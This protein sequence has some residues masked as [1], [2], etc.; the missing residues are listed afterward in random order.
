MAEFNLLSTLR[1]LNV[2]GPEKESSDALRF[3]GVKDVDTA[4]AT[5]TA[6][7]EKVLIRVKRKCRLVGAYVSPS[8]AVTGAA[9][10]FFTVLIDKRLAAAPATNV[11]LITYAADTA[12][13]DDIA[14]FGSK[15]LLA[16]ATLAT[17]L[18]APTAADLNFEEGDVATLE[19]TKAGTGMTFPIAE[20]RLIFEPRSA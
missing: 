3:E 15:D 8:A 14:A 12:T 1:A 17:Y 13:T 4:L 5:T 6:L 20:V 9:T 2:N 7:A 19:I 16:A 18:T 10:N 11:N